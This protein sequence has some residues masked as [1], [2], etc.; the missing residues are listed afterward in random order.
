MLFARRSCVAFAWLVCAAACADDA[1][2]T[3]LPKGA[4]TRFGSSDFHQGGRIRGFV[5]LEG[6]KRFATLGD[7]SLSVWDAKTG[8]VLESLELP[9]QRGLPGDAN[10]AYPMGWGLIAT[11]DGTALAALQNG[12]LKHVTLP[13]ARATVTPAPRL[14]TATTDALAAIAPSG[15][16]GIVALTGRGRLY[17][18]TA[19]VEK[20]TDPQ[21]W[22]T[23]YPGG[24]LVYGGDA[25]AAFAPDVAARA[26]N[27]ASGDSFGQVPDTGTPVR[28][29][30][31]S[32]D[33]RR[34]LL[35]HPYK[36]GTTPE[37]ELWSL[38]E[39]KPVKKW[40][41][42]RITNPRVA[43]SHSGTLAAVTGF[44]TRTIEL[45][46][47]ATGKLLRAID[48][49]DVKF[50]TLSFLGDD[51]LVAIGVWPRADSSTV[52]A[53]SAVRMWDTNT[54]KLLTPERLG[55]VASLV[56]VSERVWG[57]CSTD[58]CVTLWEQD[59]P[60]REF[61]T[62][63]MAASAVVASRDGK[64]VYT[65]GYDGVVRAWDVGTGKE[66]DA[67]AFGRSTTPG[68]LGAAYSLALSADGK[69]LVAGVGRGGL[70]FLDARDLS[71]TR[72]LAAKD[73]V[74]GFAW[75]TG[76]A[77]KGAVVASASHELVRV[78]DTAK[79]TTHTFEAKCALSGG[80]RI[81]MAVSPDG[82]QLVRPLLNEKRAR[83]AT[84]AGVWEIATG[85]LLHRILAGTAGYVTAVAFLSDGKA[86]A[87]GDSV[88]VVRVF[89]IGAKEPKHTFTG[90]RGPVLCLA[91]AL[92]GKHLAS[93]GSDA[94]ILVW[95]LE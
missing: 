69:E 89:E 56:A 10:P 40:E 21:W 31:L 44:D 36:L 13:L 11:N 59:K 72:E 55:G 67:V 71:G 66:R 58:G 57:A 81:S 46:E 4:V 8:R 68:P 16:G 48:L 7:T 49:G 18:W 82:A 73:D 51:R 27:G 28:G 60:P 34:A 25:V 22:A 64:V 74:F 6:G 47:A 79:G 62:H 24:K 5:E 85:K 84:D 53:G 42:S 78:W 52:G 90:H 38:A 29:L 76:F 93:G 33:G 19:G 54:G 45:Y 94:T 88:G 61:G 50:A 41:G 20:W 14:L 12:K 77:T 83:G 1:K 17:H 70:R 95:K 3:P 91:L 92:D 65:A 35:S 87:V 63:K 75:G 2:P 39:K 86:V 9:L 80:E 26:Y 15:K 23:K 43:L 37:F 30:A 32:S